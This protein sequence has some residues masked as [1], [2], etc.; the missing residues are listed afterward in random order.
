MAFNCSGNLDLKSKN[1][2]PCVSQSSIFQAGYWIALF[3]SSCLF[4]IVYCLKRYFWKIK[5]EMKIHDWFIHSWEYWAA[6]VIRGVLCLFLPYKMGYLQSQGP[7]MLDKSSNKIY[8]A[9]C[10]SRD[11]FGKIIHLISLYLHFT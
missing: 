8:N 7:I 11:F 5:C 1:N 10:G 6:L 3:S 9:H 2:F 4:A